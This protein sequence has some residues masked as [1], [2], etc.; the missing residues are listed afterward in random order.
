MTITID[1]P[2][3][4]ERRIKNQALAKGISLEKYIAFLLYEALEIP[5]EERDGIVVRIN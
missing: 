4:L 2:L 5:E 1:L 3:E